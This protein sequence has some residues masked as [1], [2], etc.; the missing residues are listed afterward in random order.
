MGSQTPKVMTPL[1]GIGVAGFTAKNISS[2]PSLK[3]TLMTSGGANV[4]LLPVL[5]MFV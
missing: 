3:S 4:D 2:W 5:V 1:S